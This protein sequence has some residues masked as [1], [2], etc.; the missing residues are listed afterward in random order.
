ML[1]HG[2]RIVGATLYC[3]IVADDDAFASGDPPDPGDQAG[4]MDGVFVHFIRRERRQFEERCS[5]VDQR[6]DA[7]ARQQFAPRQMPFAC[8]S[9]AAF[10]RGGA[11][12]F[13]FGNELSHGRLIG[14]EFFRLAVD[15]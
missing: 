6:H 1:F 8:A 4:S 2:H 10:S 11:P 9:R 12:A 5:G 7:L 15:L 14:T 3:R 13:Q